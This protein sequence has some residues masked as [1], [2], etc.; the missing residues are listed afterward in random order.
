MLSDSETESEPES[1]QFHQ[2]S[3]TWDPPLD[4]DQSHDEEPVVEGTPHSVKAAIDT[5]RNMATLDLRK[6]G[7]SLAVHAAAISRSD[8]RIKTSMLKSCGHPTP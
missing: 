6:V 4:V 7:V 5:L 1:S 3:S 2:L 8:A